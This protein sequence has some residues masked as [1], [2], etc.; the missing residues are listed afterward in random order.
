MRDRWDR[1]ARGTVS[2][3]APPPATSTATGAPVNFE[4]GPSATVHDRLRAV[5]ATNRNLRRQLA[6]Q[7]AGPGEIAAAW[8]TADETILQAVTGEIAGL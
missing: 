6:D 7:H 8:T 2:M 3:G 4:P 5:L 1:P